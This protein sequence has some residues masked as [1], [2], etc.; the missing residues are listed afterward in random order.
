MRSM[1][2]GTRFNAFKT[3]VT[4]IYR[5]V[6][7]LQRHCPWKYFEISGEVVIPVRTT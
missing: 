7:A 5:F 3:V 1:I 4:V 6:I 2:E